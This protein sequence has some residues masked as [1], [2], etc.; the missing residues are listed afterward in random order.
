M[1]MDTSNIED[2]LRGVQARIK[3]RSKEQ[4]SSSSS[5]QSSPNSEPTNAQKPKEKPYKNPNPFKESKEESPRTL[6]LT[7]N[8]EGTW[9]Y[10]A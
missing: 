6:L 2:L 5:S 9:Q 3:E 4:P 1:D 8:A 7:Q 10:A